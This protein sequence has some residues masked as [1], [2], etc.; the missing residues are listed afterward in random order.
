VWR[1][2][3]LL[4]LEPVDADLISYII[5][6][7]RIHSRAGKAEVLVSLRGGKK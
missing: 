6:Y 4:N 7:T 2:K 1:P 3:A 5:Y